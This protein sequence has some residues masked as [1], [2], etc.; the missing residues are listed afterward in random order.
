MAVLTNAANPISGHGCCPRDPWPPFLCPTRTTSQ[1]PRPCTAAQG[2]TQPAPSS[3]LCRQLTCW[4]PRVHKGD[5]L[6]PVSL[7]TEVQI[8][9]KLFPSQNPN[10]RPQG[11]PHPTMASRKEVAQSPNPTLLSRR[12]HRAEHP[13]A[14]RGL[15]VVC[16]PCSQ[17]AALPT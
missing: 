12:N 14:R 17:P 10:L 11:H 4:S 9:H 16:D 5:S 7:R 2:G 13:K 6:W 8:V 1:K 3:T 15:L